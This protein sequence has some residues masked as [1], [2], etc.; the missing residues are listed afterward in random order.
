[1][2]IPREGP[3][4]KQPKREGRRSSHRR[5]SALPSL[6]VRRERRRYGELGEAPWYP[7]STLAAAAQHRT[8]PLGEQQRPVSDEARHRLGQGLGVGAERVG[9][10]RS[11]NF[12]LAERLYGHLP[13][14]GRTWASGS[15]LPFVRQS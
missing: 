14:T 15:W 1:M 2:T 5:P 12:R 8:N 13:P 9:G 6:E 10:R 4:A 11:R 7:A 3:Q